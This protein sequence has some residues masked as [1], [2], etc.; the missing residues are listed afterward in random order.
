[1]NKLVFEVNEEQEQ[2]LKLIKEA[3]NGNITDKHIDLAVYFLGIHPNGSVKKLKKKSI[4]DFVLDDRIAELLTLQ[5][6]YVDMKIKKE[7]DRAFEYLY[8]EEEAVKYGFVDENEYKKLG[9]K[10][11]KQSDQQLA[12]WASKAYPTIDLPLF[13]NEF[14]SVLLKMS[15]SA[16]VE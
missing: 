3:L 4:G 12:T 13:E 16:Y 10:I 14:N 7:R 2:Q 5:N 6:R 9:K 11:P 8:N 15:V 1:M